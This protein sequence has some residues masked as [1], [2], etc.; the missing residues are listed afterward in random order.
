LAIDYVVIGA[1]IIDDIVD[2]RG[3]SNMGTLGGGGSH[4]VA[5]MRVWSEHTAFVATIGQDFPDSAMEHL[6][7]LADT[8]GI[9]LRPAPQARAWQLFET[10]GVR[11]EVFRTDFNLFRQMIVRPD[12]YPG[13]LAGAKG[14]YLQTATPGEAKVWANK[15]KSLNPDVVLL[16]E[17]WEI[18]YRP[19]NLAE[20]SRVAPLFD[21][22]SPQ[23]GEAHQMLVETDPQRQASRLFECGVRCLALRLGAAGSLVG[24]MEKQHYIPA[25]AATVVDETGAGNSYCGGFIVGYVESGGDPLTAGRYGTISATFTLS[26]IGAPRLGANSRL[27]AEKRLQQ[28]REK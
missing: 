26:Q 10:D 23:T 27:E 9:L 13:E 1:I 24:S 4:A 5:G 18:M 17:P 22:I 21:I 11:R 8:R 20:F 3:R 15:L 7:S 16:W 25:A 19:E 28:L 2:P 12:E 14:V 6:A